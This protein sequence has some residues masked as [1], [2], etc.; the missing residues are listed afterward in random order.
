M[1]QKRGSSTNS[2]GNTPS[3]ADSDMSSENADENTDANVILHNPARSVE[4]EAGRQA[5][6]KRKATQKARIAQDAESAM[7]AG[8]RRTKE[9]KLNTLSS[10]SGGR[11]EGSKM[12]G[13]ECYRCGQIGHE[14]RH[15]P[16]TS[17]QSVPRRKE[18]KDRSRRGPKFS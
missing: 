11:P 18:A 10:I 13:K 4:T 17:Q 16:Q 12:H 8:N 6:V 1:I 7:S 14:K 2:P 5:K 3:D 9:V 15:C